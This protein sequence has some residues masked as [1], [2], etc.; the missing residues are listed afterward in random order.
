MIFVIQEHPA[1]ERHLARLERWR[2]PATSAARDSFG[3]APKRNGLPK[4]DTEKTQGEI[5]V[6]SGYD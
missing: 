2:T 3:N 4:K 5:M 6:P 1:V